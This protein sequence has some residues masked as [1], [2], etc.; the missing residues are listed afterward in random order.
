MR[1]ILTESVWKH[2]IDSA[3]LRAAI[4]EGD[5]KAVIGE[6]KK[7]LKK[8]AEFFD[9]EEDE[10]EC[11][12]IEDL[13]QDFDNVAEEDEEVDFLLSQLYDFCDDNRIFLEF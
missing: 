4:E 1:A 5:L 13:I 6:A 11:Y 12:E 9:C 3:D 7:I 10:H 2:T 8:C